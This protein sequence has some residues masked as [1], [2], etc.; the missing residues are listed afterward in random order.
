MTSTPD[1]QEAVQLVNEAR[2]AGARLKVACAELGIGVNTDRR[3][4]R[5][6]EDKRPLAE[7]P[8]P[9]HALSEAERQ[10][11]LD[12]CHRPEFA[13]LPPAQ[14][15]TRQ[16]DEECRYI[17][18]ESSFYRVLRAAKEQH[19]RGRA[20]SPRAPA[21]PPRHVADGPNQVWT[22]DVTY[23]PT[24]V[25]G[26]FLY[27]YL[28]VDVYSRKI[29]SYEVFEAESAANSS[30][31]VERA[32]LRERCTHRP[33]VLHADN[34]SPMKGSTV[35]AT[36]DRLSITPSHS[37][38]RVS[39]DNAYSEALFRTCKYRP[40]YPVHG[41]DTLREARLWVLDF[42]HWYNRKHRHS[43]I[44]FVTPHQRHEGLDVAILA[45]RTA[46]YEE[47]RRRHPRRWSGELRNWDP[48]REV[49]LNPDRSGAGGAPGAAIKVA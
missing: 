16:L 46:I 30:L 43:G 47:A 33:L 35:Y 4:T 12:A 25:R 3:W 6:E 22:D 10:A 11:I 36:L 28:V 15:V 2:A 32:V 24:Y 26:M 37:R 38:P 19:H 40:D 44:R 18:S 14:I 1:R 45:K 34:G 13:S 41:F 7:R 49:W 8:T 39:N 20:A 5:N 23:L 21:P 31:V 29:V 27:L 42:V 17:A 48:I 9:A